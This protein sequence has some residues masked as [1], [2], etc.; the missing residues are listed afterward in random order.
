MSGELKF[1][2]VGDAIRTAGWLKG[3]PTL[4]VGPLSVFIARGQGA[5]RGLASHLLI[6]G[7]MC[8]GQE[9]SKANTSPLYGDLG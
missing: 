6:G 8:T 7:A 3:E 5:G 2:R 9:K 4:N 1:I